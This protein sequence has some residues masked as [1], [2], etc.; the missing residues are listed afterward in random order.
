[1]MLLSRTVLTSVLL[2]IMWGEGE[3][4]F[5][6][7]GGVGE[8]GEGATSGM[9]GEGETTGRGQGDGEEVSWKVEAIG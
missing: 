6:R 3:E 9:R 7:L 4:H 2:V 1:M 8:G 5:T